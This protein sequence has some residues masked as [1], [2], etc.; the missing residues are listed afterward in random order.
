MLS[1]MLL[2]YIVYVDIEDLEVDVDV[3]AV[4]SR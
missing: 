4:A 1:S 3:V 2:N